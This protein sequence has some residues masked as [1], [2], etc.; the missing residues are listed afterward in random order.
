MGDLGKWHPGQ[1]IETLD[2][3]YDT[4]RKFAGVAIGMFYQLLNMI[5]KFLWAPIPGILP[6]SELGIMLSR[7]RR[8]W[9]ALIELHVL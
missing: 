1:C 2:N 4:S 7:W 9:R 5:P 6:M 8:H 3:V